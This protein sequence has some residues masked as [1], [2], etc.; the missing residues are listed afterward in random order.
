MSTSVPRVSVVVAA[1]DAGST[2]GETLASLE[3]QTYA[4]WEAVV[5]DDGSVD[6]TAAIAEAAGGRVRVLR[7]DRSLGPGPARNRGV[8]EA[9]AELIA[10]LDADDLYKPEYLASQLA[11]YE[12][13]TAA[14]RR[15]GA[16]ACDADYLGPA[17]PTGE[18]WSDRMGRVERVDLT[19]LLRENVVYSQVLCPRAVFLTLGGY[20]EGSAMVGVE[21]YDLWLRMC[22]RGYEIV[23]NPVSLALYRPG[24]GSLS[25]QV[26]RT[27]R[28]IRLTLDR[29]L[30][31][32]NL[33]AAQ[34]RAARRRRRLARGVEHR[35]RIVSEQRFG[36]KVVRAL[37]AAPV[38]LLVVL[39]HPERWTR[40][41]REGPRTA[42]PTRHTGPA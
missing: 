34:R 20:D 21:D 9:R 14:G 11:A 31:R 17:G 28:G 33:S 16:V 41:L 13:A 12:L 36:R 3:A 29:A 5:V 2:L 23:V 26:E 8:R 19:T 10:L 27:A 39:E 40:W 15:V 38:V 35:A 1:R 7:N 37:R 18:R 24:P 32:G 42:G 22:E 30:D 4:N 25:S 6:D